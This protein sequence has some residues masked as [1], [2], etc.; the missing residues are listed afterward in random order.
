MKLH[1]GLD[2]PQMGYGV[3]KID[4][5]ETEAR[6][7]EAF[8]AGYR[9][10]DTAHIYGNEEGVGAAIANSGLKRE[11]LWITTK[12]WN[13]YRGRAQTRQAL[14]ESLT[15]LGLDYVDLYLIHW[16]APRFGPIEE[17][18]LTMGEMAEEGLTR[19]IGLS[20]FD[21]RFLPD[22]LDTGL[23]PVV[24]QIDLHPHF[25][26]RETTDMCEANDIR[27][28]AWGPLGQG[29]VD[30]TTGVIG[31][32]ARSHGITWA[33]TVLAWHLAKD[34]IVFPKSST[35]ERM[36]E[37]LAATQI[38]LTPDEVEAIDGLDKGEAGRHSPNPMDRHSF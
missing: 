35:P 38:T 34:H 14:D 16:P 26:Q 1:N 31:D 12:L 28:E 9:H 29:K 18:W 23:I 19:S 22:V 27:V 2:I 32:I 15:K 4:P 6:V 13:E 21:H 30:Y 36:R 5:A 3:F 37:N 8:E 20:N 11:E 24:N 10:I 25:Q 7:T 17:T 33:Q